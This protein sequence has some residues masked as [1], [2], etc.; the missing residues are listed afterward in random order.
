MQIAILTMQDHPYQLLI[1]EEIMDLWIRG[2]R[3]LR[4]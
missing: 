2:A 1:K 4:K 3:Q